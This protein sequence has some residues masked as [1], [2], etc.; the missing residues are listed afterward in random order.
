MLQTYGKFMQFQDEKAFITLSHHPINVICVFFLKKNKIVYELFMLT[1]YYSKELQLV[2]GTVTSL[3]SCFYILNNPP[4][5]TIRFL[6][7]I[8]FPNKNTLFSNKAKDF[9]S[10]SA[11]LGGSSKSIYLTSFY[12]TF[13]L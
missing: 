1:V 9:L 12:Q 11:P 2:F 5:S 6:S 7:V 13:Y 10:T 8:A 3:M 4:P